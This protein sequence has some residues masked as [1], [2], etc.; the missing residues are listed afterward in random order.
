VTALAYS[1]IA[2]QLVKCQ[3]SHF[4]SIECARNC[5][6]SRVYHS[7]SSPELCLGLPLTIARCSPILPVCRVVVGSHSIVQTYLCFIPNKT[8]WAMPAPA[9]KLAS[10]KP[11][12]EAYVLGTAGFRPVRRHSAELPFCTKPVSGGNAEETEMK[13]SSVLLATAVLGAA[14]VASSEPAVAYH[15]SWHRAHWR[16]GWHGAHWRY[17]WHRAP[18]GARPTRITASGITTPIPSQ[19]RRQRLRLS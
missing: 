11:F 19:W 6:V 9:A 1:A 14:L 12:S 8:D 17:G 5:R 2:F 3:V 16:H 4:I 18:G 10:G 15:Y 13:L 7:P